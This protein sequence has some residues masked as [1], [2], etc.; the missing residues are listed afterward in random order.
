MNE[1][2]VLFTDVDGVLNTLDTLGSLMSKQTWWITEIHNETSCDVVV[3]SM[4]RESESQ[5][6]RLIKC[7]VSTIPRR[8]VSVTPFSSREFES[9]KERKSHEIY[10]WLKMNRSP[11]F[12]SFVILD[13]DIIPGYE[14][15]QIVIQPAVGLITET[16]Q[17]AI[18]K[19]RCQKFI[20]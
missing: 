15:H 6:R 3:I 4:W 18:L 5:L 16:A 7:L 2:P 13:D 19:L 8:Y 17:T 1:R 9:T 20:T 11:G 10:Q 14:N 12:K